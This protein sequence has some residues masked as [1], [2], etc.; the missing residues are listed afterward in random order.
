MKKSNL[1][2][3]SLLFVLC[4]LINSC[5]EV[6]PDINLHGNENV[7]AD[8]TYIE[9][10]V[11]SAEVKNVII[12]EFTGVRCTNCPAGHTLLRSIQNANPGRVVAVSLHP[13][14]T[15]GT[16]YAFSNQDLRNDKANSLWATYLP[17]Q[18]FEPE[19]AVDRKLFSGETALLLDRSLWT[20]Y[21]SQQLAQTTPV[22]LKL[23]SSYDSTTHQATV[24]V[25]L[26][27]TQNVTEENKLTVLFTESDI[28]TAQLNNS[29]IDTFYTHK[30]VMRDYI[31]DTQGDAITQTRE[32]G[33]VVRKVY[34]KMLDA[35][36]K[37]E[38][39]SVVAF[40]HEH[41]NSK[42]VYQVK[43]VEVE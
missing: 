30:D 24:V 31:T 37:P 21:A 43:E 39:V 11:Q 35:A 29:T 38:N 10:S 16:P 42:L 18:G 1:I 2:L 36:W 26:H 6:G 5:K 32:A 7:V 14:N 19:A 13:R 28:T 25:E 17:D 8:T 12:E 27:Y 34:K 3:C 4:S 23:E 40:V 15:L 22:N 41:L 9:S 33:R 20:G